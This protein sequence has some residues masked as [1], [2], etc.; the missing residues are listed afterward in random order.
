MSESATNPQGNQKVV[1]YDQA[2]FHFK[3]ELPSDLPVEQAYVHIGMF[4]GWIIEQK[5]YS[6]FFE[7]ECSLQIIRFLRR[8][9][10]PTVLSEIWDGHL[11][12]DLFTDEGNAFAYYYYGGGIYKKDYKEIL[13]G[14]LPS[15]YHVQDTWDNYDQISQKITQRYQDWQRLL[16]E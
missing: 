8:E 2:K 9:I 12:S 1:V 11:G 14:D 6:E 15:V 3:G 5:L 4:M 10:S 7:D 16:S 13:A